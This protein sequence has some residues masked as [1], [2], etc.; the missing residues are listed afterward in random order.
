MSQEQTPPDL[1][2]QQFGYNDDAYP[3]HDVNNFD[4]DTIRT[5]DHEQP[6]F[7]IKRPEEHQP[8]EFKPVEH[9]NV[10]DFLGGVYKRTASLTALDSLERPTRN[11]GESNVKAAQESQDRLSDSVDK[12]AE[13]IVELLVKNPDYA[14]AVI[15]KTRSYE[16]LLDPSQKMRATA[17]AKH[18]N[19]QTTIDKTRHAADMAPEKLPYAGKRPVVDKPTPPKEPDPAKATDKDYEKHKAAQA[20]YESQ[21]KQYESDNKTYNHI[22]QRLP[23]K[24]YLSPLRDIGRSQYKQRR[25]DA[26]TSHQQNE[27]NK[28]SELPL[29]AARAVIDKDFAKRKLEGIDFAVTENEYRYNVLD[30]SLKRAYEMLEDPKKVAEI[31]E[32]KETQSINEAYES[33]MNHLSDVFMEEYLTDASYHHEDQ[34]RS[35]EHI[36]KIK[37]YLPIIDTSLAILRKNMEPSSILDDK[38]DVLNGVRAQAIGDI[39]RLRY[40]HEQMRIGAAGVMAEAGS[41]NEKGP[42]K[43]GAIYM[44]DQGVKVFDSRTP[45]IIY[46]DGSYANVN[47]HA[48]TDYRKNPDG[49]IW[50][51]NADDVGGDISDM[52]L[53][54]LTI[55]DLELRQNMALKA[56]FEG[57]N[58]SLANTAYD[59]T[60]ELAERYRSPEL[61]EQYRERDE[62]FSPTDLKLKARMLE[63]WSDYLHAASNP[64]DD[65]KIRSDGSVEE[66]DTLYGIEGR[67]TLRPNGTSFVREQN[68]NGEWVVTH[69]YDRLAREVPESE[70]PTRVERKSLSRR[71]DEF[72]ESIR[73]EEMEKSAMLAAEEAFKQQQNTRGRGDRRRR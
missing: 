54:D 4:P 41:Y 59:Y 53:R 60:A 46:A 51:P 22:F 43:I 18:L 49:S 9:K 57:N 68:S 2:Q 50:Y 39:M 56:W 17:I 20:K 30:L 45:Q 13:D 1:Y 69:R 33:G 16:A 8:I 52:E 73:R 26:I 14:N 67:W 65:V 64:A 11:N 32:G 12:T 5:P 23:D 35:V 40:R 42:A 66:S 27:D 19:A 29:L 7:D 38:I 6:A 70:E 36:E 34:E 31:L 25:L 58:Q 10:V 15:H 61:A 71:R 28:I 44:A 48:A 24:S 37:K 63:Y 47:E 62:S 55:G 21:L 72:L 3:M